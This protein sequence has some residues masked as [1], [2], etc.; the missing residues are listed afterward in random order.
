MKYVADK[1]RKAFANDLKTIYSAPN[2]EQGRINRDRITAKWSEKYPNA[3]KR[4]TRDW[5]QVYG[6]LSIMYEDRLPE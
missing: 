5:G 1:D 4:W 6:E 3:M 2:E